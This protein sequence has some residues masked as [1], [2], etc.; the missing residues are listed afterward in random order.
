MKYL[1]LELG[2]HKD[3]Q[4]PP[5]RGL[6][7]LAAPG[8][9]PGSAVQGSWSICAFPVTQLH[10]RLLHWRTG[11]SSLLGLKAH[12][13]FV[14]FSYHNYSR[15]RQVSQADLLTK[16]ERPKVHFLISVRKWPTSLPSPPRSFPIH[17]VA[18]TSLPFNFQLEKSWS[19]SFPKGIT[20]HPFGNGTDDC[21]GK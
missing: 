9:S 11:P 19:L 12:I 14:S 21:E 4:N 16:E 17:S 13:S 18:P 6:P 7:S 8:F 15:T 1:V 10:P 3:K 20:Q 2:R 5:H